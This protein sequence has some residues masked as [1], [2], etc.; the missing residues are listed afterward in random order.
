QDAEFTSTR[1]TRAT[2]DFRL[3]TDANTENS[4]YGL[5]FTDTL[6]LDPRWTLTLSG[7]YN[8]TH[9]RIEDRT[10][11]TPALN[12]SSTY[13]RFN[14]AVGINFAPAEKL[15]AYATYN[16]GMRAPTPIELACADPNAPCRLPNNFLAD[17][18]LKK[19]VSRTLEAGARG[20]LRG[21]D[22]WS[23]A[24]YRTVL[25]DDIQFISAGGAAVNAGYFQNVGRTRRQGMEFG[26]TAHAGKFSAGLRYAYVEATFESSFVVHSPNNSSADA[27]GDIQVGPG[28]RIPG[29]PRHN[30]K[31][32]LDYEFSDTATAGASINYSSSVFARGDEN[33]R[34]ANGSVPGYVVVNLDGRVELSRGLEI[35]AR[36]ANLFDRKYANFGV[37]GEN[38][39]A[40]PGKSFDPNNALPEQFRGPG[41]PRGAWLGLR[42]KWM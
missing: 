7:R 16:E 8:R 2:S 27:G 14:P 40:N 10:G 17:P 29:I 15:T 6:K 19:V 26:Y 18:P 37:L 36:I 5:Y 22:D 34:D 21:N 24:I 32:R 33:N 25:S 42:Y 13:V 3:D 4:N 39:F 11:L 9:I 38:V 28:N 20:K 41:A 23:A 12:G 35:Y 1:G 30:I 31:L